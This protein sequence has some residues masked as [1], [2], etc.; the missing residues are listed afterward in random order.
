MRYLVVYTQP[1]LHLGSRDA[2][3]KQ[4]IKSVFCGSTVHYHELIKW[5]TTVS[6][7]NER[8]CIGPV[9]FQ[10]GAH[11]TCMM[12]KHYG[13]ETLRWEPSLRSYRR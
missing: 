3:S 5:L 12:K 6:L 1:C 9:C 8:R 2:R 11:R 4:G 10:T 13:K 7:S